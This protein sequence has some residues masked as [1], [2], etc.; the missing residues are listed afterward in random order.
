MMVLMLEVVIYSPYSMADLPVLG[1]LANC[2][3]N[4]SIAYSVS[5]K[6]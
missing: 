6:R 3:N 2:G 4:T 5:S 1:V